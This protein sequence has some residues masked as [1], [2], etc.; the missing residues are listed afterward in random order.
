MI[1]SKSPTNPTTMQTKTTKDIQND[2]EFM[3]RQYQQR[4][5]SLNRYLA[6]PCPWAVATPYLI[7]AALVI[8]GIG[9]LA[10]LFL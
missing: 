6:E 2:L 10:S 5:E 4:H 3:R 7:S 9:F 1:L 8:G